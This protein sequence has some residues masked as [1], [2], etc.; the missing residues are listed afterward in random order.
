MTIELQAVCCELKEWRNGRSTPGRIPDRLKQKVLM[1]AKHYSQEKLIEELPLKASTL[2]GWQDPP[3][4]HRKL[5]PFIRLTSPP[6]TTLS[7]AAARKEKQNTPKNP[8][9]SAGI[10][11]S[12]ELINGTRLVLS[13]QPST[14]LVEFAC[15]FAR[16]LSA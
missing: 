1:L 12:V 9:S 8:V 16:G 5:T 6:P 4:S 2:K 7:L 14:K 13:G 3:R 11:L 10:T 15:A